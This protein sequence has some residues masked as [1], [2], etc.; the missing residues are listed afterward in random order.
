MRPFAEIQSITSEAEGGATIVFQ[1]GEAPMQFKAS[2]AKQTPVDNIS[3]FCEIVCRSS[4]HQKRSRRQRIT[5]VYF[6]RPF[7]EVQS[8]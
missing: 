3:M 4:K 6:A 7:A 5:S 1:N 2:Q 8:I